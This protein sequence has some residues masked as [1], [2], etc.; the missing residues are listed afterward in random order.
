M[1]SFVNV[2]LFEVR[3]N[4]NDADQFRLLHGAALVDDVIGK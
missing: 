3:D 2:A 4:I 1:Y